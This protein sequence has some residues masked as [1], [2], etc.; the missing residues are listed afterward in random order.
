MDWRA[1]STWAIMSSTTVV[2]SIYLF[3][4]CLCG[5]VEI[6]ESSSRSSHTFGFHKCFKRNIC[7]RISILLERDDFLWYHG[8]VNWSWCKSSVKVEKTRIS[9]EL[10]DLVLR[11]LPIKSVWMSWKVHIHWPKALYW[12]NPKKSQATFAISVKTKEQKCCS[13]QFTWV[14]LLYWPEYRK[15]FSSRKQIW[16]KADTKQNKTKRFVCGIGFW[17]QKFWIRKTI[18]MYFVGTSLNP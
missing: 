9:L 16:V 15:Q 11:T 7:S 4:F 2:H 8:V 13:I 5:R 17:W 3:V 6:A 18:S 10:C 12:I 1:L 14:A